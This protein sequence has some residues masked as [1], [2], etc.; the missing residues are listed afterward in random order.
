M[1]TRLL[2]LALLTLAPGLAWAAPEVQGETPAADEK[3]TPHVTPAGDAPSEKAGAHAPP[4]KSEPPSPLSFD[5]DLSIFTAIV[6]VILLIVLG[7]FAWGPIMEGLE[8]RELAIAHNIAEAERTNREARELLLSYE[9]RI[10]EANAEVRELIEQ[11]RRSAETQSQ[12]IVHAAEQAATGEKNRAIAAIG[13]AKE[14]AL[15]ELAGKSVDTAIDLAKRVLRSE[16]SPEK[17]REL[18]GETLAQFPN[19]N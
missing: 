2:I 10:G 7:K 5:P 13:A 3:A 4:A 11:G 1:L 12:A 14:A 16:I 9:K 8:K 15:R 18:I 6:F 19:R 17:H